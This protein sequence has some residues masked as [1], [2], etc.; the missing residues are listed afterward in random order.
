MNKKDCNYIRR[1][2]YRL[3]FIKYLGGKCSCCGEEDVF[4]LEFHHTD[5][6]KKEFT[7]SS[8]CGWEKMKNEV[9]KCVLLC[10]NCHS[11][12]RW[13]DSRCSD[14]K[15]KLLEIKGQK[16]CQRCGYSGR[17]GNFASLDF[18]HVN[19]KTKSLCVGNAIRF[20][21]IDR[22]K[23]I[24]ELDKCEVLCGR[25][26]SK[27]HFDFETFNK[28]KSEIYMKMENILINRRVDG[29]RII[30]LVKSGLRNYEICHMLGISKSTLSSALKRLNV[31]SN[32][33]EPSQK[34]C[35]GCGNCFSPCS[36]HII[37]CSL[38]CKGKAGRKL[39]ISKEDLTI[40]LKNETYSSLARK[41]N[42]APN[43][44]KNLAIRF[45]LI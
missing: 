20:I 1:W 34:I 16:K 5:S 4:S 41:Y 27:E 2:A 35:E 29:D 7:I 36:K 42:V 18:H 39:N 6:S 40:M 28:L 24:D 45:G 22:Q 11:E 19:P 32:K 25:C 9:D 12:L 23:I 17:D 14:L 3:N 15:V 21:T 13:G 8:S 10:R 37:F 44:I 38:K 26:H 31:K 43:T 33:A 30:Q